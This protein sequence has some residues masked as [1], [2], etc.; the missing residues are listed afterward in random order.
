MKIRLCDGCGKT[1]NNNLNDFYKLRGK[2][3]SGGIY[4]NGESS[5]KYHL[6]ERCYVEIMGFLDRRKDDALNGSSQGTAD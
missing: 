5:R 3:R 4:V 1:L 6:C 2:K